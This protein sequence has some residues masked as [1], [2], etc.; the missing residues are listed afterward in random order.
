MTKFTLAEIRAKAARVFG[1]EERGDAW[2]IKPALAL[3]GQKPIELC[4][5]P[6]GRI[7][8]GLLL[9]RL[10]YGVYT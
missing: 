8:V 4:A 7:S 9:I 5:T 3:N 6:E 1:A 2:F 10:E